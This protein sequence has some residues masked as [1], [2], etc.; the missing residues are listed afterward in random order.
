MKNTRYR[1]RGKRNKKHRVSRCEYARQRTRPARRPVQGQTRTLLTGGRA[2]RLGKRAE[3]AR[4]ARRE[5]LERE[6]ARLA[7]VA[8]GGSWIVRI[9]AGGAEIALKHTLAEKGKAC[10]NRGE[11]KQ[12]E[13]IQYS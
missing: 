9:V 6:D 2:H 3:R 7:D 4:T 5:A 1:T 11:R 12:D 13:H 10:T 8:R